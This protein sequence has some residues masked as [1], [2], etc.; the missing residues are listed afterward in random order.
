MTKE[1]YK[2]IS[3]FKE[4]G[5]EQRINFLKTIKELGYENID[6]NKKIEF[7]IEKAK[8]IPKRINSESVKQEQYSYKSETGYGVHI[9]TGM[10]GLDFSDK[11]SSWVIIT[12]EKG[13]RVL[14]REFYRNIGLSLLKKIFAYAKIARKIADSRKP[15]FELVEIFETKFEWFDGKKTLP[16]SIK[17]YLEGF[18]KE[19]RSIILKGE[20]ARKRYRE[21]TFGEVRRERSLRSTWT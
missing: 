1:S 16:F 15:G 2:G 17:Y 19:E 12:N 6:S 14:V 20:Y 11:G 8:R 13:K 21:R 3:I 10:I 5:E 7:I 9:H 4:S 18:T